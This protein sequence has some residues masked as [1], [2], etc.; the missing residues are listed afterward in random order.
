MPEL[1]FS[2]RTAL[3]VAATLAAALVLAGKVLVP[4]GAASDGDTRVQGVV[5]A[6][7]PP[8]LVVH[9]V[10]AV[11]TPGLYRLVRGARVDDAVRRAGGPTQQADLALVNLAAPV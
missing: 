2:R 4:A 1:P 5:R 8:R 11:R 6:G 9:V 10:G 3:A 7:P